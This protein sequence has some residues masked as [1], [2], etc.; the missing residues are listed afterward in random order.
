[1]KQ[2][3]EKFY[4]CGDCRAQWVADHWT[5]CPQC[6]SSKVTEHAPDQVLEALK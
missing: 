6:S 5:Q 3:K 4:Q 2:E 1:M